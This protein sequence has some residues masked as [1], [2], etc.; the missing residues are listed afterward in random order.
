MKN[1]PESLQADTGHVPRQHLTA[2]ISAEE[3][4]QQPKTSKEDI[5]QDVEAQYPMEDSPEETILIQSD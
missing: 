5:K 2:R 3:K 1:P 4:H